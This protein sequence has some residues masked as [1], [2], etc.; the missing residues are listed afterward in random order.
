MQQQSA[1]RSHGSGRLEVRVCLGVSGVISIRKES[2]R[3]IPIRTA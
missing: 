2:L 3:A 1:L